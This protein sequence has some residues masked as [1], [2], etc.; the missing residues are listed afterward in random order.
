MTVLFHHQNRVQMQDLTKCQNRKKDT[1]PHPPIKVE[2]S[3]IKAELAG[4]NKKGKRKFCHETTNSSYHL[5]GN[6]LQPNTG[7][8]YRAGKIEKIILPELTCSY[9]NLPEIHLT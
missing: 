1:P 8:G 7:N 6:Q 2:I 4:K 9:L 3:A 5:T